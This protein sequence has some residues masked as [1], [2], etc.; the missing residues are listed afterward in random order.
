MP[1]QPESQTEN[2]TRIPGSGGRPPA[3]DETRRRKILALLANGS[4]RRV[5][6]RIAGCSHSTIARTAQRDPEF[7]AELDAAEHNFEVEALR[8][9]RNA[10]KSG[11]YWRAAAWLLERRNPRD[12]AKRTPTTLS[13]E[14]A[15]N[16]AM[17]VA[18]PIIYKMTDEEFDEFQDR[19]YK[20]AR[21]L[22]ERNDL[23]DILPIPPPA[24]PV[25]VSRDNAGDC[26]NFRLSENG[27]VPLPTPDDEDC[28][29]DDGMEEEEGAEEIV[30]TDIDRM[31]SVSRQPPPSPSSSEPSPDGFAPH[32]PKQQN[33]P[34]QNPSP[35]PIAIP[36]LPTTP[37]ATSEVAL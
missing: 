24:P 20:I 19:L 7:A 21:T 16:L 30:A 13:E 2:Q 8:L 1:D 28:P 3:L 32:P 14:D 6:A 31:E 26:P 18:D 5:A 15:A 27:T 34:Q 10:A 4:S 22:Y 35:Q 33:E 29:E 37:I 17:R 9:I 36:Q 12:F 25:Y 11:R 23:A